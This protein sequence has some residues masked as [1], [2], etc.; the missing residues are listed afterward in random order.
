VQVCL[1][2]RVRAVC[3]ANWFLLL[4]GIFAFCP[5][6]LGQSG[7]V[8]DDFHSTTLNTSLWT[9]VNPRNDATL[10]MNGTNALIAVPAGVNHELWTNTTTVPRLM[11]SIGNVDFEVQTKF[12]SGLT[13]QANEIQSVEEGLMV[14]QDSQTFIRFCLFS[15]AQKVY[16]YVAT[17][18]S[19]QPTTVTYTPVAIPAGQVPIWMQVQRSGNSWTMSWSTD[20]STYTAVSTFS[21]TLTVSQIGPYAANAGASSGA[22]TAPAFTASI[23]YFFNTASP[24]YPED[25]GT[26]IVPTGVTVT[27]SQTGASVSWTTA[28]W[29]TSVV[30]YGATSSYGSTVNNPALAINHMLSITGLTCATTYHYQVTSAASYAGATK[31]TAD[32]TFTTTG[33][34]TGGGG[35]TISNIVVTPSS[36]SATVAWTTNTAATSVVKYGLT[37]SYTVTNSNSSLVTTHSLSLTGLTCTTTY[38]YSITSVDGSNNSSSTSDSTFATTACPAGGPV[39]DDFHGSTLNPMWSFYAGCCGFQKLNGTDALLIVPSVTNHNIWNQN[40]GVGLMQSISN[41]DFDVVA[42]FD[43]PVIQGAQEQGIVVQQD[44]QNFMWFAVYHDGVSPTILAVVTSNG[45]PSNKINNHISSGG[46]PFWLR[47]TRT[48]SSWTESWSTDGTNYTVATTFTQTMV[49]SGIG[50]AAANATNNTSPAPSFTAA[51]DYFFNLASPISPADGGMPA[52]PNYPVINVWYG[53]SQTFGQNGIPQ[54]W[55]NILGNLSAP[56]GIQS[57]SYTLNGGASQFLRVGPNGTRLVDSGDFNVEIDHASLNAGANTVVI[58]ATDNLNNTTTHT[59]TL[60]WS[61]TGQVWPL[62]YSINWSTASSIQ[63]VAQIVDGQWALQPDGTVRTQQV[64]YDRLIALGDETWTDYQVVA[65]IKVNTFDCNNFSVGI[66]VGWTGHTTDPTAPQPDQPR[67]GH[68]FFGFGTYA[69]IVS[70]VPPTG[71]LNIYAN[72][73]SYPEKVLVADTTG[74]TITPGVTYMM[75]FAVQRNSGNSSSQLSLKLWPASSTE[76]ANWNLQANTD[77]STGSVLLGAVSADVSFG[78]VT[79]TALP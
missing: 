41:V 23:D 59:V 60:K 64:G 79:V 30:N 78:N 51:V 29:S 2:A 17:F 45:T 21:Y 70:D 1:F 71:T 75:K 54:Q 63:S 49:V 13:L 69:T 66:V 9:F 3:F 65:S 73:K 25:G 14:E 26:D 47:V 12:D 68:P 35:P 77:A 34:G 32:A 15:D 8:S 50:P 46:A 11:Q 55:V 22:Y 42:K 62:P 5:V 33:C 36:T 18:A 76:P 37:S 39:S 44:A 72:S 31:S 52:P 48:G 38:H 19:G 24:I 16:A 7:P 43:S 67:T 28:D 20:G 10:T 53:D 74:I 40:Q 61:N 56:S 4:L 58:T 57:A 27:P 6:A